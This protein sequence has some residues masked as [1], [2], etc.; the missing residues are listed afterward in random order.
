[1]KTLC[2]LILIVFT[3]CLTAITQAQSKSYI[4]LTETEKAD[5]VAG[6]IDEI[7]EKISGR[8]Y[9]LNTRLC[10]LPLLPQRS[11]SGSPR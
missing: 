6:K 7:T 5:F 10:E 4:D 1:M 9:L 3:L 8:K 2:F 11:L